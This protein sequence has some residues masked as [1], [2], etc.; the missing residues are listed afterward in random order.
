MEVQIAVLQTA[1]GG[2]RVANQAKIEQLIRDAVAR[3]AEIVLAPELF[4]GPYFPKVKDDQFFNEARPFDGNE[5]I[6]AMQSLAAELNVVLPLSF[7]ERDGDD[8]YNSLTVVDADGSVLGLYR[9]SHI[10]TGPGYEEKYYFAPG[11]TGFKVWQTQRGRI[12]VGICWDQW[13]PEASRAMTLAGAQLL[14]YPTAIGSEPEPPYLDTRG[15][16]RRVMVGQAVANSI[17]V[18]AANRI[19][20]EDGQVFYG[21]SFICDQKGEVVADLDDVEEGIAMARFDLD[22]VESYR[23][24]FGL[25]RDRRPELYTA[26]TRS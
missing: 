7:F 3:G 19:G 26:L 21:T 25:L 12:G 9:K 15:P 8:Y 11:Q 4:E 13:F 18:A 24:D 22:E 6:A 14:F 1:L 17:P 20:D 16:W 23:R 10:P 2:S 5:M